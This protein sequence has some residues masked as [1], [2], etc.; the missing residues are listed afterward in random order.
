MHGL[1]RRAQA[2][3]VAVIAAGTVALWMTLPRQVSSERI[4]A[5]AAFSLF[6]TVA[7]LRPVHMTK[8]GIYTVVAAFHI[9]AFLLFGGPEAAWVAVAASV[10]ADFAQKKPWYRWTFNAAQYA[11]AVIA[12]GAVFSTLAPVFDRGSLVLWPSL[13]A[14]VGGILTYYSLNVGLVTTVVALSRRIPVIRLLPAAFKNAVMLFWA[15]AALGILF[16][17]VYLVQPASV[18]LLALPMVIIHN[19]L[20]NA[21]A[22][23]QTALDTLAALADMVDRRDPYTFAHS[24]RVSAYSE[25][26]ARAMGLAEDQVDEIEWAAR[27]HDVGKIGIPDAILHKPGRLT[28]DEWQVMA[29]HPVAGAELAARLRA[30]D[31]GAE[32]VRHHH[33]RWDGTG[34]PDRLA[35]TAIPLGARIIA[36]A[37]TFD[38]ITTDRPY[39]AGRTVAEALEELQASAGGQLDPAVVDA[40]LVALANAVPPPSALRA[41]AAA[42]GGPPREDPAEAVPK[43]EP[44]SAKP[45]QRTSAR[46]GSGPP[47]HPPQV[48]CPP[49]AG[50]G[51]PALAH[52]ASPVRER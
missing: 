2:Y 8:R 1:P 35:G 36:C 41:L 33:E 15:T 7:E 18:V 51:T 49:K 30:Y 42:P 32:L 9:A 31:A 12:G 5:L 37:D 25:S 27:V 21:A 16:A 45:R 20:T 13:P 50:A 4:L 47:A 17:Q 46:P 6:A 48:G 26:I 40:A 39:R 43:A 24:Q 14:L 28:P 22:L 19:A 44:A 3:I 52:R 38:A 23:R 29:F 10:I 34:Y 11:L